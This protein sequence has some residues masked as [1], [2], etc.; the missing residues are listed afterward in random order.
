MVVE[1]Q[2][3]AEISDAEWEV[4][5]AVWTLGAVT[6]RKLIDVLAEK[7]GWK[8]ATTKT[9]IGR[10]VKKGALNATRNGRAFTYTPLVEEQQAMDYATTTLFDH[11]CRMR[12]GQALSHLL[13]H[14]TLSQ[15]DIQLL[16]QQLAEKAKT[17][18]EH[19]MC[20]CVPGECHCN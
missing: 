9:L 2:A 20:N 19:V 8:A 10:L 17:A 6:S 1:K 12:S 13:A 16:Q 15:G 7:M 5:R 14:V 11:L 4:M 18:P 3:V